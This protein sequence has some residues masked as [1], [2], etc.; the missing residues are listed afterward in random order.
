ME[1]IYKKADFFVAEDGTLPLVGPGRRFLL[2]RL[3]E[4]LEFAHDAPLPPLG[5]N[6]DKREE[7][8]GKQRIAVEGRSKQGTYHYYSA[9]AS[10]LIRVY[11]II[12]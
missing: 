5:S 11:P 1:K 7:G 2:V 12:H 3:G 10:E 9:L 4:I 8:R 6:G